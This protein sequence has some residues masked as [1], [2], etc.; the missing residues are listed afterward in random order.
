MRCKTGASAAAAVLRAGPWLHPGG[1]WWPA[2]GRGGGCPAAVPPN[3][4]PPTGWD[5]GPNP[6]PG[7]AAASHG[8]DQPS[9]LHK[10]LKPADWWYAD[11]AGRGA[12]APWL[13][14]RRALFGVTPA[15]QAAYVPKSDTAAGFVVYLAH[16]RHTGAYHQRVKTRNIAET[17][18]RV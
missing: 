2:R 10:L 4:G 5:P 16:P 8:P 9:P 12:G 17:T 7:A 1:P 18:G 3:P 6:G 15:T 13:P 11:G 14:L